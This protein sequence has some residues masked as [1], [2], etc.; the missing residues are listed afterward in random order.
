LDARRA[1][2]FLAPIKVYEA[3]LEEKYHLALSDQV[4]GAR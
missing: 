4:V 1:M 3:M 2:V